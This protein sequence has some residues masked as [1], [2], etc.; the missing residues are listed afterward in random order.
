M[1]SCHSIILEYEMLLGA[2][3]LDDPFLRRRMEDRN[4][5]LLKLS[6]SNSLTG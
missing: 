3:V 1:L 4:L 5:M 6:D 2:L